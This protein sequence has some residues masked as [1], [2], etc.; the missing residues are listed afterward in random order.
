[1][2]RPSSFD[3]PEL[4]FEIIQVDRT[5]GSNAALRYVLEGLPARWGMEKSAFYGRARRFSYTGIVF[6]PNVNGP[7]HG[8]DNAVKQAAAAIEAPVA[9]YSGDAPKGW[10]RRQWER[11]KRRNVDE[12]KANQVPVLVATRAFGMGIDKPDIRYTIHL[13][14]PGSLEAFYQ[15]AGR[16]GRDRESAH[17][18]V[19][20]SEFDRVR[21]D[22]LLDPSLDI[23]AV[24]SAFHSWNAR[25][26]A[27]DDVMRA[28]WFHLQAFSGEQAELAD[29]RRIVDELGDL[30]RVASIELPFWD[31]QPGE[32]ARR[33]RDQERAIHRLVKAG[34]VMDYEV[35]YG[36]KGSYVLEVSPLDA[37]ACKRRLIGYV[38]AAQPGRAARY[39]KELAALDGLPP[40]ELA[41]RLA[42]ELVKFTYRV[43]EKSRRRAIQ[44]AMFLARTAKT[45]D[46]IRRRLLDYLREGFGADE[47]D[48]LLSSQTLKLGDWLDLVDRAMT[49]QDA[50][51]LRG[52]VIRALE[53]FPDHPG[54]LLV[55]GAVE[56]LCDDSD[57]TVARNSVAA[58]IKTG[59][60]VYGVGPNDLWSV[61]ERLFEFAAQR[62]PGFCLPL[63][64]ATLDAIAHGDD[65]ERARLR[66]INM[67]S[68][69]DHP[70]VNRLTHTE[71]LLRAVDSLAAGVEALATGLRLFKTT[72]SSE[73]S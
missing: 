58:G 27:Q 42:A 29:I 31:S 69:L 71:I 17:C 60:N 48:R 7:T 65:P 21:T 34:V 39:A 2:I 51:E 67:A 38:A 37:E 5:Q 64:L 59:V 8:V 12:F 62:A 9:V 53:S 10:E 1:M 50:H 26:E 28:L 22:T 15:E 47:V 14:M 24:A 52:L 73:Q 30:T 57:V 20:F 25:L 43:V 56:P 45:D 68:M 55:R 18:L 13:G 35:R 70:E 41:F 23:E 66:L 16:A 40:V 44:E 54:L 32:G 3:R 33:F 61:L 11:I 49:P 63:T 6:V 4:G 72:L 36:R 19:L 46:E